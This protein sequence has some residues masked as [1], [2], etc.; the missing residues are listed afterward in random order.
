[1]CPRNRR[2][3]VSEALTRGTKRK[4]QKKTEK[5]VVVQWMR[6]IHKIVLYISPPQHGGGL[7]VA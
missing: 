5:N 2:W 7:K 3:R 4:E 1:M 6:L